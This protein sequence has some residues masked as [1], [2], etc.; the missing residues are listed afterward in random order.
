MNTIKQKVKKH[1][2]TINVLL[3]PMLAISIW[4]TYEPARRAWIESF[5]QFF[6]LFSPQFGEA[7]IW[8]LKYMGAT[9]LLSVPFVIV[10]YGIL[11][12]VNRWAYSGEE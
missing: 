12:L 11:Y 10:Y 5:R 2:Y 9:L 4:L 6:L 1:I 7:A 8:L 3:A